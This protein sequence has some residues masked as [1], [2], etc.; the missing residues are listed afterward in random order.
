MSIKDYPE[1]KIRKQ[2]LTKL[3][4]KRGSSRSSHQK[5]LIEVDGKIVARV[6]IPNDYKKIMKKSKS[7]YIA[8]ALRLFPNEFNDLIV[9]PMTGPMYYELLREKLN[10]I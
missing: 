1:K 9:C 6:K 8:S 10:I 7:Q 5:A 3:K 2:I 4:P